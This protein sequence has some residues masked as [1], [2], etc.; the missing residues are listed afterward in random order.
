ML[1]VR[2]QRA[3]RDHFQASFRGAH[4]AGWVEREV[5]VGSVIPD[6]VAIR[7]RS[8]NL[9]RTR[10]SYFEAGVVAALLAI[11]P[12]RQ[13]L[14]PLARRLHSEPK[15]LLR[16][17]NALVRR[18]LVDCVGHQYGAVLRSWPCAEIVAVEAKV[19]AWKAALRQAL[20]YSTFADKVLIA[21]PR[22]VA[23]RSEVRIACRAEG[24]GLI[25]YATATGLTSVVAPR[26]SQALQSSERLRLLAYGV[27]L[28]AS[29]LTTRANHVA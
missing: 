2:I 10:L 7:S 8:K 12:K 5:A 4:A 16:S 14:L 1:E 18:G 27:G 6:L 28:R 29:S 24:V 9:T 20:E 17:L 21:L 15:I 13:G 23:F 11:S 3:L 19:T 22:D 26:Q 25:A